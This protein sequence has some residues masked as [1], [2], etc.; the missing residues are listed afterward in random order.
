MLIAASWSI[1]S[2]GM[3]AWKAVIGGDMKCLHRLLSLKSRT[4][5]LDNRRQ[6]HLV[7]EAV[8]S[9]SNLKGCPSLGGRSKVL[10]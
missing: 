5:P 8:G 4:G 6:A 1:L 10:R 7:V 2:H 3:R 9:L